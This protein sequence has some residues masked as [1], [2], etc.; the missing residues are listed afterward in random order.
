M[1]H[2][3]HAHEHYRGA[4]QDKEQQLQSGGR[5]PMLT[6]SER[7]S[8]RGRWCR[9][10]NDKG[11]AAPEPTGRALAGGVTRGIV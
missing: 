9:R 3:L 1:I 5:E 8:G 2:A 7:T 11:A 4:R 10:R 6:E